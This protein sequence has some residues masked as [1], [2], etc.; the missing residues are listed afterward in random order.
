MA[1]D[2]GDISKTRPPHIGRYRLTKTLGRGAM[3]VVYL[4]Y[5]EAIDRQVAIKTIHRALLEGEDGADG[6][7]H[8]VA[9]SHPLQHRIDAPIERHIPARPVR[10]VGTSTA[11]RNP[12]ARPMMHC[13]RVG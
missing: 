13:E 10:G 6:A 2:S 1:T 11:S 5:D 3:G 12:T 7:K 8:D 4:G 9:A